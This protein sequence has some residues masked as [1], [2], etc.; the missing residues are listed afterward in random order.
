MP[1]FEAIRLALSQL[2]AQKLKSALTLLGVVISI[3]FLVTVVSIIEGINVF[4]KETMA[5]VMAANSFEL[6]R[7][8]GIFESEMEGGKRRSW[9]RRPTLTDEDVAPVAEALPQGAAWTAYRLSS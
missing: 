2:R 5:T 3:T 9:R 8:S 4:V 1:L 6:R 7:N